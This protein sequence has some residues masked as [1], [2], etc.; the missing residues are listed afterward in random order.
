MSQPGAQEKSLL[1]VQAR[2]EALENELTLRLLDLR[3][4]L[5]EC[6]QRIAIARGY[7]FDEFERI[8]AASL[9]KS[10]TSLSVD[11]APPDTST[12][13][14][15]VEILRFRMTF[16]YDGPLSALSALQLA[17][18][19]WLVAAESSHKGD[20]VGSL[21]AVII[22]AHYL[23]MACAPPSAT[24]HLSDTTANAHEWSTRLHRA[25][26]VRLLNALAE[27]GGA[28][29]VNAAVK[30]I[31]GPFNKFNKTVNHH[32][33]SL[34]T[35][36]LLKRWC[37]DKKRA[38]EVREAWLAAKAKWREAKAKAVPSSGKSRRRDGI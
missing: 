13:T 17:V 36:N 26:A 22:S 16:P 28:E 27:K 25:E 10:A 6:H 11:V 37:R 30:K 4:G 15:A 12:M 5:E 33:G 19:Y 32:W 8:V 18:A 24:E 35:E 29:S 21:P 38:P 23:G 20:L 2:L 3:H 14:A 9:R 7:S 1:D 34:S 31:L